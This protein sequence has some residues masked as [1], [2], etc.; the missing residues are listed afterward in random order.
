MGGFLRAKTRAIR[1][2]PEAEQRV[3]EN[4]EVRIDRSAFDGSLLGHP[5][6]IEQLGVMPG[7]RLDWIR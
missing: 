2:E 5:L 6:D 7:D 4:L 3:F 1:R